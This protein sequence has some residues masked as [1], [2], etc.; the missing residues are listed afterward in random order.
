MTAP[1]GKTTPLKG[2]SAVSHFGKFALMVSIIAVA[3]NLVILFGAKFGLWAP[4]DGFRLYRGYF[5]LI[6]YVAVGV[7]LAALILHIL[8]K[9]RSG[10]LS[11]AL[12]SLMGVALLVPMIASTLNPPARVP[13]IHDI[14]TDTQN[15]PA[16]FVLDETRPNASNT[17]AYGGPEIAEQQ[18]AAYPDIAPIIADMSPEAAFDLSLAVAADMGWQIAASDP[19]NL[20][21]EATAYTKV[22]NFADDVVVV[23]T[24]AEDGS[25]VDIRSVSRVGRSD[26]GVNAAR[27]RAFVAAFT[28]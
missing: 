12:A 17:L 21:F 1:R 7:G 16:F 27:I 9:E 11:A 13:P 20:R 8:R 18:N 3:A 24:P 4:L 15:P 23:V 19:E 5:N 2:K 28:G 10:I 26:Q 22:F 6:A 25:R 14:T